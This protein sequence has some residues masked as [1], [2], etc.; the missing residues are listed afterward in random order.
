MRRCAVV[1]V[2]DGVV[3]VVVG[4]I[5]WTWVSVINYLVV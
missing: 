2:D 3:T 1:V 5:R 4:G